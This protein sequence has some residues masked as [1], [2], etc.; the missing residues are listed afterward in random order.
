VTLQLL[1]EQARQVCDGAL[2]VV[3]VEAAR[4]PGFL[5][6]LDNERGAAGGVLVGMSAPQPGRRRLE[7]E[8][9]G[10]E[11]AGAAEPDEAVAA[12]VEVRLEPIGQPVADRAGDA[13][14]GDDQ[15]GGRQAAVGK[16]P[17][18]GLPVKLDT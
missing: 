16:V 12:P 15:I 2:L 1:L 3:L 10:G 17:D 13:V 6:G 7:V 14:G 4:L 18:L 9:E 5:P 11:R 8:G